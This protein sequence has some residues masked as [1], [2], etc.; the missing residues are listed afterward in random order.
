MKDRKT[1]KRK[2]HRSNGERK[3][4]GKKVEKENYA[5]WNT[6]CV[7]CNRLQDPSVPT[8][9]KRN[10]INSNFRSPKYS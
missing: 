9:S 4:K 8:S 1:K 6:Y 3:V 2:I 5:K 10:F 7:A